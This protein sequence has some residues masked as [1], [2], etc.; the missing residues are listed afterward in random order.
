MLKTS[1]RRRSL[2]KVKSTAQECISETQT[3]SFSHSYQ[4]RPRLQGCDLFLLPIVNRVNRKFCLSKFIFSRFEFYQ[5]IFLLL[6][7]SFSHRHS[8]S[9]RLGFDVHWATE[10]HFHSFASQKESRRKKQG[11]RA[12]NANAKVYFAVQ[13][14]VLAARQPLSYAATCNA[15]DMVKSQRPM[16]AMTADGA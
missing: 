10:Y 9:S 15:I 13:M 7:R 8:S 6:P 4:P 12:R 1:N 5:Q 14:S 3:H 11:P 16:L 2:R